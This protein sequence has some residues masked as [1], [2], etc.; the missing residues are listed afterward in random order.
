MGTMMKQPETR[1]DSRW[2]ESIGPSAL[3]NT[4]YRLLNPYTLENF[5]VQILKES[6][7]GVV[8]LVVLY[9]TLVWCV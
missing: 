6:F 1:V 5:A 2:V 4:N 9:F 7:N 8:G 3:L